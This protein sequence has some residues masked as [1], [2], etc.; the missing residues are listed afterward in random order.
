M[1]GTSGRRRAVT[2]PTVK[3][4]DEPMMIWSERRGPRLREHDP[5]L[6]SRALHRLEYAELLDFTPDP[7]GD[8]TSGRFDRLAQAEL[9][10]VGLRTGYAARR[11]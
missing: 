6:A 5:L 7:F 9:E 10:S 11:A 1:S 2:D 3:R 8:W 4:E